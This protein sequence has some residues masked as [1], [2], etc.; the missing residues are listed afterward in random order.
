[1]SKQIVSNIFPVRKTNVD[2]YS[3]MATEKVERPL[4]I[5]F[6]HTY[7]I[8]NH[9]VTPLAEALLSISIPTHLIKDDNEIEIVKLN[10][11]VGDLDGEKFNCQNSD[12]A[13]NTISSRLDA[14]VMPNWL[15]SE[16]S[17]RM[18]VQTENKFTSIDGKIFSASPDNRTVYINTTNP[19]V[20]WKTVDCIIGPFRTARSAAKVVLTF[21]LLLS[22]FTRELI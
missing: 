8:K 13:L 11:T 19:S 1:M 17:S 16:N 6:Q 2:W 22:N 3:Y 20:K 14:T 12:E 10:E 18:I 9:E 4:K 21:E 15:M 7:E 5:I